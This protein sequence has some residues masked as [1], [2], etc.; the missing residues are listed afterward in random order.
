L[1]WFGGGHRCCRGHCSRCGG[2][3]CNG[4]SRFVVLGKALFAIGA[5]ATF[6]CFV[7]LAFAVTV[8]TVTVAAA[9]TTTTAWLI[10]LASG[11]LRFAFRTGGRHGFQDAGGLDFRTGGWHGNV[12]CQFFHFGFNRGLVGTRLTRWTWST[13]GALATFCTVG[14]L[15]TLS[16]FGALTW[17]LPFGNDAVTRFARLAAFAWFTAFTRFARRTWRAGWS[18]GIGGL[19]LVGGWTRCARLAL[20][21]LGTAIL[22]GTAAAAWA[23][24]RI[25]VGI[26]VRRWRLD[27][28]GRLLRQHRCGRRRVQEAE[29]LGKEAF[30]R[31][32]RHG[33]RGWLDDGLGRLALDQRCRL[34]RS[35][36]LDHGFLARLRFFLLALA[37][38]HVGFG[39][40]GQ[41]VA[42]LRIFQAWIVVLDTLQLVVW[43]F[44]VLVRHQDDG[45]A[46]AGLDFQHFAA[47]FIQ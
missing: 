1:D 46:V 26:T 25:A 36:G 4:H 20:F 41:G 5:F 43:G 38:G 16:A 17:R 11:V 2:S 34:V 32:R 39:L 10:T 7:F 31:G 14:A 8:A 44:Q 30:W 29:Q 21:A 24:G 13:F 9:T 33:C 35:D 45:D 40:L 12:Q 27:H 23:T 19:G 37:V 42:G 22:A 47:L 15:R 3:G 28:D 18:A 6:A